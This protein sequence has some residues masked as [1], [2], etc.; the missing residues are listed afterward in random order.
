MGEVLNRV[1]PVLV[2]PV[3]SEEFNV[4]E[5][6][7]HGTHEKQL[8]NVFAW[9]L[10]VDG[11]HRLGNRF[12]RCFL[13]EVN[14]SLSAKQK[15]PVVLEPFVVEQEQNT[16][17]TRAGA[18]IADIVLQGER[19]ALVIENYHLS[20]GHGHDYKAYKEHGEGLVEGDSVVVMLCAIRDDSLLKDGWQDAAVVTYSN[21]A[22]RLFDDIGADTNYQNAYPEQ[23]W[24][25]GQMAKH[26]LKGEQV[27]DDT[28]LEFI[29]VL[30]DT[31]E[32]KHF[33]Y[34]E[35]ETSFAA[36]I[37]DEA[38]R[39][40]AE[41]KAL[42]NRVKGALK[43]YLDEHLGQLNAA[44]GEPIFD[45][46]NIGFQGIYQWDVS[47]MSHGAKTVFVMFGPSAWADNEQNIF[48]SWE[49]MIDEPDYSR[50]VIGYGAKRQLRQS[51]V[52]M[53]DIL[54]GLAP[55]DTRLLGEIVSAVRGS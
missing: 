8:S 54:N 6:M 16:R 15:P 4:F 29:K 52:T 18:D 48:K 27:N 10:S 7:H 2:A 17:S 40:F 34:R 21:L 46:T 5:V 9:L 43:T 20:D 41:G 35:G 51:S 50:L 37:R 55:D 13:D 31:G 11:S 19:T 47:L 25:L 36:F 53:E 44:L 24:F 42:L 32:A 45:G 12:L 3:S 23:Y 38:E 49:V 22:R 14:V 28:S 26:F 39:K 30:C 33:G 1:L